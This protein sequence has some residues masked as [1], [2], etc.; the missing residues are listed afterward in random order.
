[1]SDSNVRLG[2]NGASE[3]KAHPFFRG[4]DW[5][6]IRSQKPPFLPDKSSLTKNFDKFDE[7]EPWFIEDFK[8]IKRGRKGDNF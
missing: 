4:I 2:Q 6:N 8:S 1:M 3:I 5:V 7:E